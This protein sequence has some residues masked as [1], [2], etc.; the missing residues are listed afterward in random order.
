MREAVGTGR[1]G[2][3]GGELYVGEGSSAQGKGL[4]LT[5]GE[6]RV[7][8]LLE[9][10]IHKFKD[11][12]ETRRLRDDLRKG[13]GKRTRSSGGERRGA[14]VVTY[15]SLEKERAEGEV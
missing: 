2:G 9:I 3:Y 11:E 10:I 8:A 6:V 5:G 7:E 1:Q 15:D 14:C 12:V 4:V 13:R